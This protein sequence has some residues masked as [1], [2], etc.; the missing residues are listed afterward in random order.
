[1][2]IP[3]DGLIFYAPLNKASNA[4]QTGQAMTQVGDILYGPN[5]GIE[6]ALFRDS[7]ISI[8]SG[9][10]QIPYGQAAR[11]FSFWE[12]THF[13]AD[14]TTFISYGI[15]AQV[16]GNY[17][18]LLTNT[19]LLRVNQYGASYNLDTSAAGDPVDGLWH[20]VAYT[21]AG[22]AVSVY[23]DGKLAGSFNNTYNVPNGVEAF[24]IANPVY[25]SGRYRFRG[26]MAAVRIYGR[27][28]TTSQISQ[29]ASQFSPDS[30]KPQK[31]IPKDALVFHASLEKV[32]NTAETGQAITW[33]GTQVSDSIQ[34][35]PCTSF[36]GSLYGTLDPIYNLNSNFTASC[37]WRQKTSKDTHRGLYM[38]TSSGGHGNQFCMQGWGSSGISLGYG[39]SQ[40][41]INEGY[42]YNLDTWYHLIIV[43][44]RNK[45]ISISYINGV[46]YGTKNFTAALQLQNSLGI[47]ADYSGNNKLVG[48]MA[49][50]RI[51]DRALTP[52]QCYALYTEF[53]ESSDSVVPSAP[54]QGLFVNGIYLCSLKPQKGNRGLLINDQFIPIGINDTQLQ[55]KDFTAIMQV[56]VG[57][58]SDSYV[59]Y[60]PSSDSQQE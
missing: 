58:E 35:I 47:G 10:D 9:L 15:N 23:I 25:N 11:T 56:V 19:N 26:R 42:S 57:Q 17:Q 49:G 37:W 28:L 13:T 2:S 16:N 20:H 50:I 46:P 51:Y 1:M 3:S 44:D 60:E 31:G 36:N 33:T 5:Q 27:V 12:R 54:G 7:Y 24:Y 39:G 52:A 6:S 18:L 21:Q 34:G 41:D 48:Y 29:L 40:Y 55:V 43:C 32:S 30:F 53:Q 14:N 8:T 59:P 45:G 22:K 4:A 38:Q